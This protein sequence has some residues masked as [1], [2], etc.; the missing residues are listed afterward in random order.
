MPGQSESHSSSCIRLPARM[1]RIKHTEQRSRFDKSCNSS[2]S[3]AAVVPHS[4]SSAVIFPLLRRGNSEESYLMGERPVPCILP[5][6]RSAIA[7]DD[8]GLRSAAEN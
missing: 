1:T 8:C 7:L 2:Y 4:G 5:R 3:A 6:R